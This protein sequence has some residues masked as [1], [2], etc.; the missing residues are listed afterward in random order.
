MAYPQTNYF[1]FHKTQVDTSPFLCK[2]NSCHAVT[3]Y[4]RSEWKLMLLMKPAV[5]NIKG[6]WTEKTMAFASVWTSR[7]FAWWRCQLY[8]R[9][10]INLPGLPLTPPARYSS[11]AGMEHHHALPFWK[12]KIWNSYIQVSLQWNKSETHHE[13]VPTPPS[14]RTNMANFCW[15]P[16]P[17]RL[18]V[19]I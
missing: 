9:R 5:Y 2:K 14:A 13:L 4:A 10:K 11:L 15:S 3:R 17:G 7:Q 6:F 1:S 18:A 12:R 8:F 19:C 16:G